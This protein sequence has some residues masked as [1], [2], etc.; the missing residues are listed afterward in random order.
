MDTIRSYINTL[1]QRLQPTDEVIRAKEELLSMMEDKYN[2]LI[3]DGVSENE[4]IGQV[5]SEFGNLDELADTLGIRPEVNKRN[6]EPTPRKISVDEASNYINARTLQGFL[7]GLSVFFYIVSVAPVI[8]L[9]SI[10]PDW[11]DIL[12]VTL[13]FVF[14]AAGTVIIIIAANINKDKKQFVKSPFELSFEAKE[15][16]IA[17]K[18]QNGTKA[19]VFLAVGVGLCILFVSPAA[20]FG[21]VFENTPL[22]NIGASLMFVMCG[23]GVW[24]IIYSAFINGIFDRLLKSNSPDFNPS[25]KNGEA[26]ETK[27]KSESANIIMSVY[28][29]TVTC[30]YLSVSFITFSW[31]STWI[32][33]V[34]AALTH[35]IIDNILKKQ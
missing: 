9:D 5:I 23:I 19:T 24:M 14:V 15:F 28:W 30:I 11:G 27:Y 13:M 16:C 7:T 12:G 3:E 22:E 10:Y 35:M 18:K 2:E 31:G 21:T 33:W 4:A 29:P 34:I 20:F 25:I 8:F 6:D 17:S 26:K 1:F 32:I